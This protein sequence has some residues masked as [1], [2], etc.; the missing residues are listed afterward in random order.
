MRI[1]K[2]LFGGHS[3]KALYYVNAQMPNAQLPMT[4]CQ[5]NLYWIRYIYLQLDF[6]VFY[7]QFSILFLKGIRPE[8]F[9]VFGRFWAKVVT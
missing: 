6:V 4:N 5:S 1:G 2:L 9:A 7:D 8:D 3:S